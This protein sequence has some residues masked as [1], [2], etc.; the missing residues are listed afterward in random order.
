MP[1]IVDNSRIPPILKD[2]Y[3]NKTVNEEP[4]IFSDDII[5]A[6]RC[7]EG[8]VAFH[9]IPRRMPMPGDENGQYLPTS[10]DGLT[11]VHH[12]NNA[13]PKFYELNGTSKQIMDG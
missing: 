3:K 2:Q 6:G 7:A 12:L 10:P 11:E 13:W 1:V 5:E 4:D 8:K 9:Q